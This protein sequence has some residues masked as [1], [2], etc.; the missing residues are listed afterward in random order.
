VKKSMVGLVVGFVAVML[1]L[2]CFGCAGL[3]GTSPQTAATVINVDGDALVISGSTAT[4]A[5]L[6]LSEVDA[7][8]QAPAP[9]NV[10]TPADSARPAQA[11]A[12]K[13]LLH[14]GGDATSLKTAELSDIA[15]LIGLSKGQG[16]TKGNMEG[17][18]NANPTDIS[19]TTDLNLT[20]G[21]GAASVAGAGGT[22][23]G[24]VADK[25][26][27]WFSKDT[28]ATT[29]GGTTTPPAA[30][31]WTCPKCGTANDKSAEVCAKPGCGEVCPTCKPVTQ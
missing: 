16:T 25:V 5:T 29:A 11:A 12:G 7:T 2:A 22:L 10:A 24:G 31:G 9:G 13:T 23:L 28:E 21:T 14:I 18:T 4:A 30:G 27:G 15:P 20:K 6:D 26:K 19:P 8:A 3:G 17:N 1:L